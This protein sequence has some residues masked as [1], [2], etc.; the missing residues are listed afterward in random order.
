MEDGDEL[1][2]LMAAFSWTDPTQATAI[3]GLKVMTTACAWA[4]REPARVSKLV[5]WRQVLACGRRVIGAQHDNASNYK[6]G[7]FG[8]HLWL[9]A[10]IPDEPRRNR[11][12]SDIA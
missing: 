9:Q 4:T 5:S 8:A 12:P 3:G 2:R 11:R 6:L 7:G 1:G 10:Q